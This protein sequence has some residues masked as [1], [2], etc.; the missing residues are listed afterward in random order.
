[1]SRAA[2]RFAA[3]TLAALALPG[4]ALGPGYERPALPVTD[5]FRG[6]PGAEG[7]SIADL[8]WWEVFQDPALGDLVRAALE[9]NL[10]LRAAAARVE[11][12][13]YL[14]AIARSEFFPQLGYE[15]DATTGGDTFLGAPSPGAGNDDAFLAAVNFAWEIDVWGR[16]RRSSEAARA[17]LFATEAFRR[18]VVLSLVAGVAQAY[19]ELR[20]LDFELEIANA[21]VAT[22]QETYDIFDRQF[23]GG[24]ASKLDPLRAEAALAQAAASIPD[25]ERRIVAKENEIAVLTGRPPREVARG[26]ALVEQ[27]LP[28]E[29]PA[30]VPAELL[31]RRPDLAE[32]E[33]ILVAQNALVGVALAEFFPR[34]GLTG[35]AGSVSTELSSLLESGTGLWSLAGIAAGPIFTFGRNLYR[36]EGQQAAVEEAAARYEQ[37]VLVALKEVSD[38]L[39]ARD[40]LEI[41]RAEQERAVVALREGLR[42]ARIRYLGGLASYLEVL[43][44]QQQLFPAENDLART[45]RDQLLAVVALYRA[46]G[47]GWA[48]QPPQPSVPSPLAP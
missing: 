45:R 14:A 4:C 1:V 7:A 25:L 38:A 12:A 33:Q 20:E 28:P 18:G 40:K 32:A 43:D 39:V 34:I 46:H 8:P 26:A 37:S 19:F 47:G 24:V 36:Y 42:I 30:G 16:I 3:G 27:Q 44:A 35:L 29:V 9:N 22:F 15:A 5:T 41:V 11:Q 21:T 48:T 17:E 6:Q 31:A 10:D 2:R 13:R 23:R